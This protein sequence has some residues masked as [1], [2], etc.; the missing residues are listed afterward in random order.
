MIRK[1]VEVI[2]EERSDCGVSSLLSIIK[3][4]GG[5]ESLENLRISSL[6]TDKGVSA[7]NLIECAKQ[8]GFDCIGIKENNIEK[9]NLPCIAHIKINTLSHFVVIYKVTSSTVS[10]MDPAYGLIKEERKNFESCFTGVAIEL[11]P[12]E[13]MF[14]KKKKNI[15]WKKV[16]MELKKSIKNLTIIIILNILFVILSVV[17]SNYIQLLNITNPQ[18]LIL[19]ILIIIL[20]KT[21]EYKI[22]ILTISLDTKSGINITSNFFDYLF[23]LP[24]RILQLKSSGE[25]IKRINELDEVKSIITNLFLQLILSGIY[26]INILLFISIIN[27]SL[28]FIIIIGLL[29]TTIVCIKRYKKLGYN[30]NEYIYK[31]TDYN[32]LLTN[33]IESMIS[34]KHMSE[35]KYFVNDLINK[36]ID[37][38]K[39]YKTSACSICKTEFIKNLLLGI[40]EFCI[41]VSMLNGKY[42]IKNILVIQLLLSFLISSFNNVINVLPNFILERKIIKKVNEFYNIEEYTSG[43]KKFEN[44]NITFKNITFSYNNYK[45]TINNISFEI[46]V[47]EHVMLNGP[48]G[49]GKSTL[50][51]LL[52]R[53]YDNYKGNIYI[54]NINIK[55]IDIEEYKKNVVYAS[56]KEK[57]I[58]GTIKENILFG[59]KTTDEE[60]NKIISISQ[61]DKII[62]KYPLGFDTYIS[63]QTNPLSGGETNLIILARTLLQNKKIIILDEVLSELS[64]NQEIEVLKNID[65][66]ID[67]T[68]IYISHKSS[69]IFKEVFNVRKD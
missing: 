45:N 8:Y 2:Q 10:I 61:I 42:S 40:M 65:R 67:K 48:S 11:Y 14:P 22:S 64:L 1:N 3:Y 59:R 66:Y 39:S 31:S 32:V 46:K 33:D 24:L 62:K 4:Y 41:I 13:K 58:N 6:T 53:D 18:S 26:I 12:K 55:D 44:G 20:L 69:D 54:N 9:L 37:Y 28:C 43:D 29:I 57:I 52:N 30:F 21:I 17:Y 16:F 49:S 60:F 23:N 63:S 25:I 47:G 50:M 68:I 19:F 35:E 34:I 5:D 51:K 15:L 27:K 56:Q 7:Y 36:Y 38:I